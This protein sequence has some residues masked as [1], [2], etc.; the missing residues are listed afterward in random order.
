MFE[1]NKKKRGRRKSGKAED[2]KWDEEGK[3]C[4]NGIHH[5]H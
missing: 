2:G 5:C 3:E 4:S 1:Q